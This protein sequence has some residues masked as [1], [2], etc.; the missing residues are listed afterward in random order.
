MFNPLGAFL[1]PEQGALEAE[2]KAKLKAD[3][4]IDFDNLFA[5]TNAPGGRFGERLLKT[6]NMDRYMNTLIG[7][8]N[9][10]TVPAMM[11]RTQLSVTAPYTT[12]TSTRRSACHAKTASPS[13]TW[14]QTRRFPLRAKSASGTTA[15][16]VVQD[17]GRVEAAQRRRSC[18]AQPQKAPGRPAETQAAEGFLV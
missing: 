8:F 9:E 12:A 13:P 5:I 18:A 16:P 6:N 14:Q 4:D 2:Y 15:M 3:F 10:E 11:C 17:R 7:A 1:P